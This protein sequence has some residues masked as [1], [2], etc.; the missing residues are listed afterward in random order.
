MGE[1]MRISVLVE[2]LICLHCARY[3][4]NLMQGFLYLF[5]RA[6][7]AAVQN[8]VALDFEMDY[9]VVSQLTET[10]ELWL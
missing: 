1:L 4:A 3:F 7:Q 6:A 8:Y 5:Q 10:Q 9:D 2:L